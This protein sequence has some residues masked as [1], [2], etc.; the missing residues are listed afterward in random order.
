LL[1]I[2]SVREE[3]FHLKTPVDCHEGIRVVDLEMYYDIAEI[4][5]NSRPVLSGINLFI[6]AGS[7]VGILGKSRAGKST[8]LGL[9][10]RLLQ[11]T[12]G[13]I[14]WDGIPLNEVRA[15]VV[16][17]QRRIEGASTTTS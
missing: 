9:M 16:S 2:S 5:V 8:L 4:G 12:S 14:L 15:P 7:S 6:P 3:D 13:V 1:S 17:S 11:P 10:A